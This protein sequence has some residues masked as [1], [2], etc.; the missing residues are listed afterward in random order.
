MALLNLPAG[1]AVHAV[2]PGSGLYVPAPHS[3]HAKSP[4][5]AHEPGAQQTPAPTPLPLP[6]SQGRQKEEEGVATKRLKRPAGQGR[7]DRG[8]QLAVAAL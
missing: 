6:L 8:S 1:H 5:A 7:Q 4:G 3:V 2:A